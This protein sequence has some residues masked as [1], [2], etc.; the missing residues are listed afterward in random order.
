MHYGI[1]QQAQ[2]LQEADDRA[3]GSAE[4][5]HPLHTSRTLLTGDARQ[6]EEVGTARG[7]HRPKH[8]I[9]D[10]EEVHRR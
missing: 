4:A 10:P 3:A 5:H 9:P 8:G 1:L 2:A 6:D 7:C